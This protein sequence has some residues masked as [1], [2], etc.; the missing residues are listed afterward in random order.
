MAFANVGRLGV[1]SGQ[2]DR[3]IEILTRPSGEK[4]WARTPPLRG[5]RQRRRSRRR[6]RER[7]LG[8]RRGTRRLARTRSRP[9]R[10]DAHVRRPVRFCS[11]ADSADAAHRRVGS[12]PVDSIFDDCGAEVP[13]CRSA[14]V[15]KCRGVA[16][17]RQTW[18]TGLRP[19]PASQEKQVTPPRLT[20][21]RLVRVSTSLAMCLTTLSASSASGRIRRTSTPGEQPH[22]GRIGLG[23]K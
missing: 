7:A 16:S 17:R 8:V 5:R 22:Q 23:A 10:G 19:R 4:G 6:V 9:R 11:G 18:S 20:T 13:K 1:E 2:R 15:P 12:R 21:G 3:L 14:E